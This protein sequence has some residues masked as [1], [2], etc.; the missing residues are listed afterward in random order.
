M[1][2]I[3]HIFTK[4]TGKAVSVL[5]L[6]L[7]TVV[8]A[9]HLIRAAAP[10]V[11]DVRIEGTPNVGETLQ[12]H[13]NYAGGGWQSVGNM[14]P[15]DN[16]TDSLSMAMNP[17]SS[18]P[19]VAYADPNRFGTATVMKYDGEG[20]TIVG[21]GGFSGG[22][23]Q[24][25]S[26]AINSS[27]TPYVVYKD[28]ENSFGA[29]VMKFN[30]VSW[31]PVGTPNL[32]AGSAQF[33]SIAI[34]PLDGTPY[35]A[36]SYGVGGEGNDLRTT[37]KKYTEEDGWTLVGTERF[38]SGVAY[39]NS[40]AI[41]SSGTPYVGYDA[42]NLRGASVM[43]YT[44]E[45]GWQIIG[46][47][48]ISDGQAD[49]TSLALDPTG[50]PYIAY[51]DWA[52]GGITVKKY[53]VESGWQSV[54]TPRL[55]DNS[56]TSISLSIA[57]DGTP[58]LAYD[59][60]TNFNKATVVKFNETEWEPVGIPGLS[61][62]H[63]TPVSVVVNS[64]NIPYVAYQDRENGGLTVKKFVQEI[65]EGNSIYKWYKN[66]EEIDGQNGRSYDVSPS[67]QGT[68][69][70]FEVT[71]ISTEPETGIPTKSEGVVINSFPVASDVNITGT[72]D[73]EQILTGNY[74][75]SDTDKTWKPVGIKG[76]TNEQVG[77]TSI[78]L[79]KNGTPYIA[80]RNNDGGGNGKLTVMKYDSTQNNWIYVGSPSFSDGWV[81]F[82][83]IAL[84][85]NDIPYVA[86]SDQS[87]I[88]NSNKVTVMKYIGE[89]S[90]G[91][92]PV[93]QK[94]FSNAEANYTSLVLDSNGTPYV[95]YSECEDNCQATVMKHTG[96]GTTGWEPVGIP[97]F[98]VGQA[99][100]LS[101]AL[102]RNQSPYVAYVGDSLQATVMKFDNTNWIPVG[103][104]NFSD[105]AML[106]TLSINDNN[107]PYVA[108]QDLAAG[109]ITVKKFN[110]PDWENVG[111]TIP[112]DNQTGSISLS[113]S[114]DRIP[115]LAYD[116]P[117]SYHRATLMKYTDEG[118]T[119]W[120]PV[121]TSGFSDGGVQFTSLVLDPSGTPYVVYE[122]GSGTGGN[123]ATVMKFS[124]DPEGTS[125]YQW[126]RND[127]PI[128]GATE[129]T[130][131]TTSSD[132]GNTLT[133][134]ITP[135]A[136]TGSNPGLEVISGGILVTA[137]ENS[138]PKQT[139]GSYPIGHIKPQPNPTSGTPS[140][141]NIIRNLKLRMNGDDVKSLQIYLNTHG[142]P[143][144]ATG[145]GSLNNETTFFG[146]KTKAAVMAFQKAHG[147]T[148]DG[149][150]GPKTRAL[151]K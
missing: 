56:T 50:M 106:T 21:G 129:I 115:Y 134:G 74:T 94:R 104:P 17:L 107:V 108:Y 35:V 141:S 24:Y 151:M 91:W 62:G 10:T 83:S 130:Y 81:V 111:N 32:S 25:I 95:G 109:G 85:S 48:Q 36:Y 125:I 93:G 16:Y 87:D 135:V 11:S 60:P 139:T 59:D 15:F 128:D 118:N 1:N 64:T 133:F 146:L 127:S 52:N 28:G 114:P 131:T 47:E 96:L 77:Y 61:A 18:E 12:G 142:Y 110:N 51:Q 149:I 6:I 120:R 8:V 4:H 22:T 2:L 23:V 143:V 138:R 124:G 29:T 66:G 63:A 89:G 57:P 78:A 65:P 82:V 98:S 136:Q 92:V 88:N 39:F 72:H 38:T 86:Y 101:L 41:D 54:G 9:L 19:Y 145:P 30:G 103:S 79:S 55:F 102:D 7:I 58:Y 26:M 27:G 112:F 69:I 117:A 71:P 14:I 148:P 34:N 105:E 73:V 100:Y 121:G 137:T 126:Y 84:D 44:E 75:Y 40:L 45:G 132:A 90:T 3:K 113:I 31:E 20:W 119:G 140:S 116:D 97:K 123:R 150:V 80:Y 42:V 5:A 43:K 76:F 49:Q 99:N 13:Y 147:L 67:D 33:T 37:V 144:S 46:S 122:D 53:T 70:Q 68:T